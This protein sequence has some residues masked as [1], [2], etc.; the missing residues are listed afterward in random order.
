MH[1][2]QT[3]IICPSLKGSS[4]STASG[5]GDITAGSYGKRAT[6]ILT[7]FSPH[8]LGSATPKS[9]HKHTCN[10]YMQQ[11]HWWLIWTSSKLNFFGKLC[12]VSLQHYNKT[13]Y[14]RQFSHFPW[15]I[16]NI[17]A[18]ERMCVVSPAWK[19]EWCGPGVSLSEVIILKPPDPKPP[20]AARETCAHE[21]HR[22]R[23]TGREKDTP[24]SIQIP[25][26]FVIL[27]LSSYGTD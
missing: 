22:V 23:A 3:L 14:F 8:G 1:L 15:C 20:W 13:N 4:S 21:W 24:M 25:T 6:K 5:L 9:T 11:T 17:K 10:F 7:S 12:K 18:S 2:S 16:P 27:I 19:K 26:N